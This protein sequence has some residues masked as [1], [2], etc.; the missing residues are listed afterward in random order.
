L[1]PILISPE[2]KK[3]LEIIWPLRDKITSKTEPVLKELRQFI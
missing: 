1:N 2:F 3:I